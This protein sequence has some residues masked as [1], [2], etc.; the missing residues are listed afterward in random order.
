MNLDDKIDV[1]YW[2]VGFM[3]VLE[4]QNAGYRGLAWM[5]AAVLSFHIIWDLI[6]SFLQWRI[7][8]MEKRLEKSRSHEKS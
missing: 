5:F 8:R 6:K 1:L 4:L 3:A 2:M 7:R